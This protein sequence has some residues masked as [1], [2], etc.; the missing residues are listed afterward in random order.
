MKTKLLLIAFLFAQLN[1]AQK[2]ETIL[3]Q[4]LNHHIEMGEFKKEPI[5][6]ATFP[7]QIND[8]KNKYLSL[9]LDKNKINELIIKS[10][11]FISLEIPFS[12]TE[13]KTIALKK[14]QILHDDFKL[15]LQTEKGAI[16]QEM[17]SYVAY[18]GIVENEHNENTF[19]T[20]TLINNSL[21]GIISIGNKEY[22]IGPKKDKDSETEYILYEKNNVSLSLPEFSCGTDDIDMQL[23]EHNKNSNQQTTIPKCV[24]VHFEVNNTLCDLWGGTSQTISNITNIFN[25]VQ[26]IYALDLMT[27]RI[28]Y[29]KIYT[30]PT[31]Y[32]ET[33]TTTALNSFTQTNSGVLQGTIGTLLGVNGNGGLAWLISGNTCDIR[34]NYCSMNY[35]YSIFPNYSWN[36]NVIAHEAGHNL[37]SNH[38]QWCGWTGGALDNCYQTE[39]GC[40]SGPA[41]INGGTI[42][43][44]CHLTGSGINFNNGFGV[45]PRTVITNTVNNSTCFTSCETA[46]TCEDNV[47]SNVQVVDNGS[48]YTITWSSSYPVKIY[49][50]ENISNSFTLLST[51]SSNSYIADYINDCNIEKTEF[52]I[53]SICPNG[54]SKPTVIVVS[55]RGK[56]PKLSQTETNLCTNYQNDTRT[57]SLQNS[58]SYNSFQWKLNG[59]SITGAT[60]ATYL[61]N[62]LGVYSCI[63]TNNSGCSFFTDEISLTQDNPISS[64]T[65][66][67][68][69]LSVNFTNNSSCSNNRTWEFGDTTTSTV[70]NPTKTYSNS[71][72]YTV[73]INNTNLAGTT[74]E[75]KQIPIFNSWTEEMEGTNNGI[76]T[77]TT[78]QTGLCSQAIKFTR[79]SVSNYLQNSFV[80]YDFNNF[81]PKQGTIELLLY[82]TGGYYN[83]SSTISS[84][85]AK[86]FSIGNSAGSNGNTDLNVSSNGQISGYRYNSLTN[87]SQIFNTSTTPFSFNEWNV[88]SISYGSQGTKIA[89]NGVVYYNN[90][91]MN[92][93]M[94]NA[95]FNLGQIKYS[96]GIS[97]IG[98]E[99]LVDKVRFSYTQNDFQL[100]IPSAPTATASQTFCSGATVANLSANGTNL[101][102]YANPTVGNP[103]ASNF[104]LVSG[105][106]FVSQTINGCESSRTPVAVTITTTNPPSTNTSQILCSGATVSNLF[107]YSNSIRWYNSATGGS[108]LSASTVVNNGIYYVSQLL[109]GCESSRVAVNVTVSNITNPTVDTAYTSDAYSITYS[110]QGNSSSYDL[111]YNELGTTNYVFINGVSTNSY[112]V[113]G[114]LPCKKYVMSVRANCGGTNYSNYFGRTFETKNNDNSFASVPYLQDFNIAQSTSSN[115]FCTIQWKQISG[116]S[117]ILNDIYPNGNLNLNCNPTVGSANDVVLSRGIILTAGTTYNISYKYSNTEQNAVPVSL[118]FT[119]GTDENVN[120]HTILKAHSPSNNTGISYNTNYI[121][122]SILFTPTVSAPHFFAFNSLSGYTSG[123]LHFDDFSVSTSLNNENFQNFDNIK[124]YP[125]PTDNILF[126]DATNKEI[127]KIEMFDLQ[128]KLLKT[129]I[130]NK[131][132]YQIN[133]QNLPSA[134][135]LLQI[136]TDKGK[137]TVKVIKK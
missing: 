120:N 19:V 8:G 129:I 28:S 85:S 89:V 31:N 48:N 52:K 100:A 2:K 10:D 23:P 119:V 78:Y 43:S 6:I 108:A 41:P 103:L 72:I 22:T 66:T 96:P 93:E 77:N 113:T 40:A 44:Y 32:N 64:F 131:D 39:G 130:E 111:R 5:K 98:F 88:V 33:N 21:R 42:M 122:E 81:I 55:P 107:P 15:V 99:G 25:S 37:G 67:K 95:T 74:Q 20:I 124:I 62:Q 34:R 134:V 118:N 94:N 114:L 38:T 105:N 83:G 18:S 57:L 61:A 117:G 125:N 106:Y 60:N 102:W 75:C 58:S 76:N 104:V 115:S 1:F 69:G 91:N 45:Q 54:D 136:Q 128:G 51:V 35:D 133:L 68:N 80:Q 135:Y 3:E 53:V 47:V 49:R 73:C 16:T 86:I 123:Y 36:V 82:V 17:P 84:T 50:R 14:R 87:S 46:Q 126:V 112:T 7:K 127:N 71:A 11:K 63:V 4:E 27:I 90:V 116:Y 132:K 59:N 137:K 79:N 13:H 109:N 26:Q 70:L 92:Y 65:Y 121:T 110:W 24:T 97:F 12:E 9:N 29:L 101:T 56:T 30:I